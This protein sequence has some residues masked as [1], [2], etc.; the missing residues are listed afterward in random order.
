M[1]LA[2]IE[3]L[4]DALGAPQRALPPCIHVAGTNGKGSTVAF[5]RA[6]AEAAGRRVHVYTSPHLVRFNERIRVAG[7]LLADAAL[8]DLLEEVER[9]N[10]GAPITF[11]EITTAAAFLAFARAPADLVLLE[12][13]MGG[14]L[15]ATNVVPQPMVS[16]ITPIS[17]DH[18]DYLGDT[19]AEI[20]GEKAGI[21]K[22]GVP[23]VV[24]AQAPEAA[25]VIAARARDLGAPL[26][27]RGH[28]WDF[29]IGA[30]GFAYRGVAERALPRPALPGPHQYANA[31]TAAAAAETL[32]GG[33][34]LPDAALAAGIRDATWPA[35]LQRL[36]QGPLLAALPSGCELWLDGGHNED[37]ARAIADWARDIAD[38]TPLDLVMALRA[39]KRAEPV[40]AALRP[41]A[42]RLVCAGNPADAVAAAPEQLRDAA[43]AVG[44][45]DAAAAPDVAAA[46]RLLDAP[47]RVLICGSL[48]LAGVVLAENG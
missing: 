11:F 25:A 29:A 44:F 20:A 45:A 4:L 10:A 28:E 26:F 16:V 13:G 9:A 2:R 32:P 42:R 6:M 43:R 30:A 36:T 19:L 48:Y 5:L 37:G 41:V 3:R 12:V 33:L 21:I 39:T 46:L 17:L 14:R 1:S 31:A 8:A 27:R 7:A 35:R 47:R 34:R 38:G 24:G 15:D 23:V 22:P 18:M 40:F